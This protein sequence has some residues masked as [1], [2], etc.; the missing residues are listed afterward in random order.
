M[1]DSGAAAGQSV[2]RSY[3][4]LEENYLAFARAFSGPEMHFRRRPVDPAFTGDAVVVS[5]GVG[6]AEA[7]CFV[8]ASDRRPGAGTPGFTHAVGV[9][10]QR[11]RSHV[12]VGPDPVDHVVFH[13]RVRA[14]AA[15]AAEG[16][17]RVDSVAPDRVALHHEAGEG[18]DRLEVDRRAAAGGPRAA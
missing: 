1:Y 10:A 15:F 18:G 11:R 6:E 16:G 2:R 3:V 14:D 12:P 9:V 4:N 13:Q 17:D 8:L 5:G 7:A